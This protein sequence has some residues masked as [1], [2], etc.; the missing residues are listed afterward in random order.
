MQ[1]LYTL[2]VLFFNHIYMASISSLVS[3]DCVVCRINGNYASGK[4]FVKG[5]KKYLANNDY[6]F[7]DTPISTKEE[8][9][10]YRLAFPL[11]NPIVTGIKKVSLEKLPYKTGDLLTRDGTAYKIAARCGYLHFLTENNFSGADIYTR[12][13]LDEKGFARYTEGCHCDVD[14]VEELTMEQVC[15]ELGRNVKIRRA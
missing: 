10:G 7:S 8:R 2:Y 12:K 5:R 9:F 4:V 3:G 1:Q 13:E 15:E 14:D 11:D 6:S